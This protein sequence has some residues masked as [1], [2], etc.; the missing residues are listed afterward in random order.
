MGHHLDE[1]FTKEW[2][3]RREK[4]EQNCVSGQPNDFGVEVEVDVDELL[5]I[6]LEMTVS[7]GQSTPQAVEVLGLYP[8]RGQ[9]GGLDLEC[10]TDFEDLEDPRA[11]KKF[12]EFVDVLEFGR[13]SHEGSDA[14]SDFE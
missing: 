5:H 14:V 4:R 8:L 3:H 2:T 10:A 6:T 9:S 7:H 11:S 12:G 1:G 13:G